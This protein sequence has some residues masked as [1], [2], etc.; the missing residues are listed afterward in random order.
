MLWQYWGE[1]WAL[2][3]RV[4]FN[5][6]TRSIYI[7]EGVTA[8]D[9]RTHVYSAWV[10][11]RARGNDHYT[12]A[13]RRTGFDPI[14]GGVTGD[15]YFLINEWKLYA[16]LYDV[17]ISGVLYSDDYDTAYYDTVTGRAVYPAEVS[18]VVNTVFSTTVAPGPTAVQIRE[19]MDANSFKLAQIKAIV[20]SMDIPTPAQNADAV[21]S[22]PVSTM[23][24]KITIGGYIK[25]ALLT[26]PAFLGLK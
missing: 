26:I 24:D 1:E 23:T 3:E 19:E 13:M 16:D 12:L 25:K 20:E 14:P 18:S 11:W 15:T 5:G 6:D 2:N 22:A 7:H 9:I 10:R 21:W 8:L 4:S 17:K